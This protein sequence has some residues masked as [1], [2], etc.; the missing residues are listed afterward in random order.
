MKTTINRYMCGYINDTWKL[1]NNTHHK[2]YLGRILG[3]LQWNYIETF[4]A[5]NWMLNEFMYYHIK[6]IMFKKLSFLMVVKAHLSHLCCVSL[7][8]LVPNS[9]DQ[10]GKLCLPNVFGK[11][12][13]NNMWLSLR[14]P[15]ML[16]CKFWPVFQ[17]LKSHYF[18]TAE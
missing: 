11:Q 14:K 16:A 12:P 1:I 17:C 10:Q 18:V 7:S 4:K 5:H 9:R 13:Y 8:T 3:R 2:L 15:S 6:C